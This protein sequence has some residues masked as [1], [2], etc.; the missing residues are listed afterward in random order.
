M[1]V[2]P[3]RADRRRNRGVGASPWRERAENELR[4]TGLSRPRARNRPP[5]LT[6]REREI[7]ELAAA[8]LTSKEIGERLFLSHRTVGSHLYQ[9]FPKLGLRGRAGLRDAL[10]ALASPP[11]L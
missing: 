8:G 6:A 1:E 7:A 11:N 5:E 2:N 4:A 3:V 10:Q 9:V